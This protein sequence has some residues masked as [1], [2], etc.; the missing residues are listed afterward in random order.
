[1][2]TGGATVNR[3]EIVSMPGLRW[4]HAA[5]VKPRRDFTAS[6]ADVICSESSSVKVTI[7]MSAFFAYFPFGGR[8]LPLVTALHMCSP[9]SAAVIC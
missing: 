2:N 4:N 6:T 9:T 1:M 7:S 5:T 8:W 3:G